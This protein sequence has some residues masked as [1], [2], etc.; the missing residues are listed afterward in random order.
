MTIHPLPLPSRARSLKDELAEATEHG[1][2]VSEVVEETVHQPLR[3]TVDLAL[4][5]TNR[6]RLRYAYVRRHEHLAALL[7]WLSTSTLFGFDIET[8]GLDPWKD[9]IATLQFGQIGHSSGI[10]AWVLDVRA[11]SREELDPV[12]AVLESREHAKLGQNIRFEYRFLRAHYGIRIRRLADTQIAEMIIRAGLLSPKGDTARGV[13]RSAY[14]LCSMNAL[15]KRYAKLEIDKDKD[16]RTSFFATPVGQHSVRQII[17]AASDVIYP[18]VI[19]QAQRQLI[20][21]R[22]LQGIV[23]VEMEL[24]PVL[25]ELEHVGVR[26]DKTQWRALWQE[27][28][29]ARAEAEAALDELIRPCTLQAD[30]FDT[31]T[32]KARPLYPKASRPLNY[33]SSDQ[34]KW[35]IKA[36]CDATQWPLPVVIDKKEARELKM[37][38][39]ASWLQKQAEQGRSVNLDDLPDWLIPEGEVCLLTEADKGTLVLRKSRKQLPA[40]IVDLLMTY[41]KY[42][43]RCDTFGND[44]LLKNVNIKTGRVHTEVHQSVTNTGRLS[45]T[46][47]LQNIPSD[48]RYRQCFIPA[49]GKKFVICDYSQQEPRL[50]AQVSQDPVYLTTYANNDDLYL[51]VAEAMLGHRPDKHTPEGKLE[52][53]IFKIIVLAMAYRAGARKLRDQLTLGMADDIAAGRV[54][55]P[56]LEYAREMHARFFQVHEKVLEYQNLCSAGADPRGAGVAKIWDDLAA[57]LVTYVRA[58]CGRVRFFPSTSTNTYTEA[59]NAPI[60]GGSATM[61]KAASGLIQRMIEDE[62]W[63]GKAVIINLVHDEI[64]A[65]VDDDIAQAFA[66]KMQALMVQAGRFYCPDVAIAA[67]F[68][69]GSNGVVPYWAKEIAA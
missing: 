59:S 4:S 57:D 46:P 56:T 52:R 48:R 61:I 64:V 41:S 65:E 22:G 18:F 12:F 49:D 8:N 7:E 34:V 47:N 62:G 2:A 69:E 53:K 54:E 1:Y 37:R 29:G 5:E 55:P 3:F 43:I 26:V 30:L 10:D 16:L 33:S 67:E 45:T 17:Y 38:Y 14:R 63:V 66:P 20:E 42:D 6:R 23:K 68:P 27:A 39:G 28:L 11:F 9:G 32:V 50:L 36:Y 25:G 24:I 21:D 58:P 60:Q 31:D 40:E 51:A 44:W 19:A 35:A 15:M 13:D